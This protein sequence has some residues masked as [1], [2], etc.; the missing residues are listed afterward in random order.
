MAAM[1]DAPIVQADASTMQGAA[2]F[3]H[4]DDHEFWC[5]IHPASPD[6]VPVNEDTKTFAN[7]QAQLEQDFSQVP[8]LKRSIK[9]LKRCFKVPMGNEEAPVCV[10]SFINM[11][12]W[13]GS[14]TRLTNNSC[15][16]LDQIHKL[17]SYL[18]EQGN[19]KISPFAG[20]I[21]QRQAEEHLNKPSAKPES[22]LI[23]FSESLAEQGG[24]SLAVKCNATEIRHYNILGNTAEASQQRTFNAR[25]KLRHREYPDLNEDEGEYNDIVEFMKN[26]LSDEIEDNVYCTYICPNLPC[27]ALF[28]GY[29]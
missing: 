22:Y 18:L 2:V 27:N 11:T 16:F 21:D 6:S 9:F 1:N 25:L 7:L 29:D 19:E 28:R 26:R 8:K 24:F 13:F 12:K 4:P 10:R 23:R 5:R 20:M 3:N 17:M 15:I 14:F